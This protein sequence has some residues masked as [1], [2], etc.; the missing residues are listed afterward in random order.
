MHSRRRPRRAGMR[1]PEADAVG[2]APAL[3]PVRAQLTRRRELRTAR[4]LPFV[5]P[6]L[7]FLLVFG[8]LPMVYAL[9]LAFS[10]GAGGW[11]GLDNFTRTITDYRFVPAFEHVLLYTSVWLVALVLIVVGLALLLHGRAS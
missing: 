9:G 3:I 7:P 2:G 4:G 5:L 11:A 6:Y 1:S 8:L 10:T